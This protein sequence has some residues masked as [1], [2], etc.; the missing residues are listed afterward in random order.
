MFNGLVRVFNMQ[1]QQLRN[2][3]R[4]KRRTISPL[5]FRFARAIRGSA[6]LQGRKSEKGKKSSQQCTRDYSQ[7]FPR[8]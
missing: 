4:F 5:V 3:R 7:C 8:D 2:T 6:C 1:S